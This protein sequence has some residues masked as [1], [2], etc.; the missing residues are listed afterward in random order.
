MDA[1]LVNFLL[2]VSAWAGI[3][4]VRAYRNYRPNS[5]TTCD[6]IILLS[7]RD[8]VRLINC[9]TARVTREQDLEMF[10]AVRDLAD[11]YRTNA[12]GNDIVIF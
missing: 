10:N 8:F 6:A 11:N 9:A 2:G 7:M 1:K 4:D 3:E 5:H 12:L